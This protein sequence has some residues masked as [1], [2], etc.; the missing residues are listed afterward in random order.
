[1]FSYNAKNNNCQVFVHYLLKSSNINSY[2]EF[3]LQ[4]IKSIFKDLT[5]SRQLINIYY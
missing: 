3:V 4:D 2:D 1:M 5:L